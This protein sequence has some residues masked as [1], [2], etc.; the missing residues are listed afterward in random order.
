MTKK[1]LLVGSSFSAAPIFF[2]LKKRGLRV[3][4]C[5]N[6]RSDPCHQYADASHY[7]D[8]SDKQKLLDLVRS[9]KF[10]YIVPSCNDFSYM[11]CTWVADKLGHPGFDVLDVAVILHDKSR[12]REITNKYLLRAPRSVQ[13]DSDNDTDIGSLVFPLLVKPVDSFSGRGVTKITA[14]KE[15][16]AAVASAR[17]S[18]RSNDIVIEEFV[19]GELHSHSAFIKDNNIVFDAFVDEYCTVYPYQ[20]NCSNHPS[21]LPKDIQ[22]SV[23]QEVLNLANILQITDGLLHTQ[24]IANGKDFWIIECM[25]RGPGDLYGSLVEFSTGVNYL[26]L[27]VR[28]FVGEDLPASV[29]VDEE[30]FFSRHTLSSSKPLVNFT[31][32]HEVPA[33]N[34]RIVP[35]KSSGEQ[36]GVAPYDKLAILFAEYHDREKMSEVSPRLDSFISIHSLDGSQNES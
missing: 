21:V 13:L 22:D 10:D 7:I 11:S 35:L 36:L 16:D 15:L 9:E 29:V 32:S 8:Y 34:V 30:K 3:S 26:D 5:G 24:F 6:E 31:F 33:K 14:A 4:V 1:V 19:E 12:F 28:S 20:V 27:Y 23:R 17:K 18:S 2:E 25:R